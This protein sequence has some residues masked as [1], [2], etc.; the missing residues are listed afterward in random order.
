[1]NLKKAQEI[2]KKHNCPL[3]FAKKYGNY[4]DDIYQTEHDEVTFSIGYIEGRGK[5]RELVN[6]TG[7]Y[8]CRG[9]LS[10]ML[11]CAL[12]KEE[13]CWRT[14][15]RAS[16]VKTKAALRE[17]YLCLFLS[18]NFGKKKISKKYIKFILKLLNGIE[19]RAGIQ[20]TTI[21]QYEKIYVVLADKAW[22][23]S[24]ETLSALTL[25]LRV[26]VEEEISSNRLYS[27]T[28]NRY[29][30]DPTED[31]QTLKSIK[32]AGGLNEVSKLLKNAKVIFRHLKYEKHLH[33]YHDAGIK[34]FFYALQDILD[35]QVS[36][37]A[38]LYHLAEKGVL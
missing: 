28:T 35:I 38:C 16:E 15:Y 20:L 24:T 12:K 29:Y 21:Q 34:S 19:K 25:F 27:R 8:T 9:Y 22:K 33:K 7:W 36:D 3:V 32:E 2:L 17:D 18:Q 5:K 6:T 37:A 10:E 4:G 30:T 13:S 31:I 14:I 1:M 23:S 26:C 11:V